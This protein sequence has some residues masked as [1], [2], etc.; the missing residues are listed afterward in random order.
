MNEF[1][2][3]HGHLFNLAFIPL[4]A[5]AGAILLSS[6]STFG[7]TINFVCAGLGIY[8]IILKI[9]NLEKQLETN[10]G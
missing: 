6:G 4:N 5:A 10:N 9:D 2:N 7:A 3:K 1:M 8:S